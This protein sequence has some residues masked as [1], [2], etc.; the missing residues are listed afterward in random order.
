MNRRTCLWVVLA[1]LAWSSCPSGAAV[2]TLADA[3]ATVSVA[4]DGPNAGMNGWTIN[5]ISQLAKQW[6]SYRIGSTDPEASVDTLGGLF[7][8]LSDTNYDGNSETLYVRYAG[9]MLKAE[10]TFTLT[11]SNPGN[12]RS[13]IGESIRLT[14]LTPQPMD[15][16]FFQHCD[17]DLGGTV[18]DQSVRIVGG[19]TAQQTDAGMYA[20]ETVLMPLPSHLQVESVPDA[21]DMKGTVKWFNDALPTILND[22]AGPLGP[23]DLSWAFQWDF[24]L[25]PAG[26]PSAS[27]LISKDKLIVPEPATLSLLALGGAA[28]LWRKRRAGQ[29]Q[30][31]A[32]VRR[33]SE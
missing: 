17:L 31:K 2:A 28:I 30:A 9:A 10:L 11:G 23:G 22:S 8:G 19:N 13:D 29:W 18:L 24:P 21:V 33:S 4:L 16:H 12:P 15:L 14:N 5:G 1:C 32:V 3:N 7:Y 20:S 25:G 26:S 27:V 6:F